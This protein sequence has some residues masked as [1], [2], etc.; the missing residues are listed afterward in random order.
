MAWEDDSTKN[1]FIGI[2][3]VSAICSIFW[4]WGQW[5]QHR[6]YKDPI[7]CMSY[8]IFIKLSANIVINIPHYMQL[9]V[10]KWEVWYLNLSWTLSAWMAC[11]LNVC[12]ERKHEIVSVFVCTICIY[13]CMYILV[14]AYCIVMTKR[15]LL[16]LTCDGIILSCWCIYTLA[17]AV[18]M[19]E[20]CTNVW[21]EF[22]WKVLIM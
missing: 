9:L 4:S 15:H 19:C 2:S 22:T 1:N 16:L 5:L 11:L 12:E 14:H 3:Y 6:W 10:L 17:M 20:L 21:C 8:E 7:K 18:I 13:M